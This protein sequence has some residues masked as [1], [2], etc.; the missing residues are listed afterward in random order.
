MRARASL[1]LVRHFLSPNAEPA[2]VAERERTNHLSY[3]L[4][5]SSSRLHPA[6]R[7]LIEVMPTSK[8]LFLARPARIIQKVDILSHRQAFS[9]RATCQRYT[10]IF[11]VSRTRIFAP[12]IYTRPTPHNFSTNLSFNLRA[13][14]KKYA[15]RPD[16]LYINYMNSLINFA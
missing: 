3:L 5:L 10:W 9:S 16:S 15:G 2:S 11:H 8:K 1:S 13:Y 4:T 14:A 7:P 6:C 12:D